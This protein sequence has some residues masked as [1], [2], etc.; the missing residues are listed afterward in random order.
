MALG[1]EGR[2]T[3]LRRILKYTYYPEQSD[4]KSIIL[5]TWLNSGFKIS[6]Y[7]SMATSEDGPPLRFKTPTVA[8][9]V[10]EHEM[11]YPKEGSRSLSLA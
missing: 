2:N 3:C 10:G 7:G 8:P 1:F 9:C 11:D 4:H 6:H 5:A